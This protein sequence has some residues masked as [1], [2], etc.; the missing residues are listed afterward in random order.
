MRR[1]IPGNRGF[2]LIELM[3]V[4][5]IAGVLASVAA[6]GYLNYL[7][8]A[9]ATQCSV[10]RGEAQNII[11]QYYQSHSDTEI[12]S[13]QQLINEG[14]LRSGFNCPLGGEYVLIPAK[15]VGSQYPV[16][17]CSLHYMPKVITESIPA[18]TPVPTPVPVPEPTP[19]PTPVPTPIPTPVPASV[20]TPI[21]TQKPLTS[22]GSS[23]EEISKGIIDA[24]EAYYEKNGKYPRTGSKTKYTDIGLDPNEWKDAINGIIYTPQGDSISISP[25]DGYTFSVSSVSGKQLTVSGTGKIVYS[26]A[27]DQWYSS[28]IKKGDEVKISTLQVKK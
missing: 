21:P 1:F 8:R 2:T 23:F 20:P 9:R 3:L 10:D 26:M 22:L 14:Y 27:T 25:G 15:L 18:P 17:A 28:S 5:A 6:P 12:T 11:I 24:I 13:L 16:I 19:A 7:Q 4:I